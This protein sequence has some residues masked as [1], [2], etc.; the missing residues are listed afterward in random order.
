M[1]SEFL[2]SQSIAALANA[3]SGGSSAD[4]TPPVGLYRSGYK[5]GQFMLDC[6]VTFE[7]GSQSRVPALVDKLREIQATSNA[8]EILTRIVEKAVD[9]RDFI[10]KEGKL[11]AVTAYLNRFL[12]FDGLELRKQGKNVRLYIQNKETA[13]VDELSQKTEI[14]DFDTVRRDLDRAL[15]NI[16]EDPEDAL[17]AAC[18]SVESVCRSIL[19]E[20]GLGLPA[21]KDL[22]TLYKAVQGPLGLFPGTQLAMPREIEIDT[23]TILGGMVAVLHGIGSLRT[24]IGDAHGRERKFKRPDA[25]TAR[26]AIHSASTLVLFI[27]ETWE[28]KYPQKELHRH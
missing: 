9:P 26:L 28:K 10:G 11:E 15:K 16:E 19:V 27:I 23:R 21:N 3:I 4:S 14:L 5:L 2:S 18:S 12:K 24:H 17:T 6:H 22:Q 25:R 1:G 13:V 20:L 8:R 7:V